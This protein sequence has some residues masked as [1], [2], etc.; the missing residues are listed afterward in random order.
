[1]QSLETISRSCPYCGEPIELLVDCTA[2]DQQY[3]EDCQVCCKP[4]SVDLK[5]DGAEA[6]VSLRDENEA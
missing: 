1:M 3:F 5:V 4:I 2:G 6:V